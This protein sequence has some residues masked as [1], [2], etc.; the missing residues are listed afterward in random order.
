MNK[1]YKKILILGS[2]GAGKS[3]LAIKL[4]KKL[5]LPLICL[6]QLYWQPGWEK[7]EKEA[8]R[9]KVKD[10]LKKENWIMDGNYRSTLDLRLPAA[11]MIIFLD[12]SRWLCFWRIWK[13]RLFGRRED[14]IKGCRER[15]TFKLVKWV[16]W[17]F[18]RVN[19][20]E[21][22]NYLKKTEPKQKVLILRSDQ[23]AQCLLKDIKKLW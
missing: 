3:T 10:L 20:K 6:D 17:D 4:Q 2:C 13:R 22:Y 1:K 23:E 9:S 8:W 7:T 21:L 14:R 12:Y 19:R 5:A 15:I 11:D 18:P 16:L